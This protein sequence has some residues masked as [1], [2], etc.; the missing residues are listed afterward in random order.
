R[1]W[2]M[3]GFATD[4]IRN[5]AVIGHSGSG[6]TTLVEA[7]AMCGGLLS[8]AG[9]VEDGNTLSDHDPLEHQFHHSIWTSVV[10]LDW[11]GARI[12]LLDAPGYLDFEGEVISALSAAD[13][14]IIT[15]DGSAGVEA[16]TEA[17]WANADLLGVAARVFAV[18][19]L[20]REHANWD[21]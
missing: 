5:V 19:R 9:R 17:A 6:K 16:G 1:G 7:L 20:D 4:R 11:D 15:V 3:N 21:N 12:N 10:S 8:R 2:S 13:S 14:A 18:T